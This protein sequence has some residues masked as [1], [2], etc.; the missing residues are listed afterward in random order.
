MPPVAPAWA[1]INIGE[2]S[3]E[4]RVGLHQIRHAVGGEIGVH[5]VHVYPITQHVIGK[6]VATCRVAGTALVACQDASYGNAQG[7]VHH[8][9][10]QSPAI[11]ETGAVAGKQPQAAGATGR[12]GSHAGVQS[13]QVRDRAGGCPRSGDRRQ[14]LHQRKQ[15][16]ARSRWRVERSRS[17]HGIEGVDNRD[18]ERIQVEARELRVI[19][20][21]GHAPVV[22]RSDP[23]DELVDQRIS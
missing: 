13:E 12:S 2:R 5:I 11:R 6:N 16:I 20:G 15:V 19:H 23:D 4:V 18:E 8:V 22:L 1:V 7:D 14:I 9:V 3:V 21:L 17:Q 10:S